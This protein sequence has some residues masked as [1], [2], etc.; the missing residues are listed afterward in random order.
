MNWTSYAVSHAGNIRT[1]NQDAYYRQDRLG[2]WAVAD[3]MG[4]H[5]AGDVASQTIV[6]ALDNLSNAGASNINILTLTSILEDVNE[7][8]VMQNIEHNRMTGST[9]AAVFANDKNCTCLWAGDSRIYLYRQQHLLQLSTDHSQLQELITQG[10]L[11][12]EEAKHYKNNVLTRAIGADADL[13]FDYREF[14]LEAGDKLLLCSDGLYNEIE[15]SEI[16]AILEYTPAHE[17]ANKLLKLCLARE[18]KD[19]ISIILIN[20]TD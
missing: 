15:R 13:K 20:I 16:I 4:G 10:Q 9:I 3:G 7:Q 11:S 17:I 8:L 19:N 12:V 2:L 6:Q 1:T 18:A 14:I 5:A